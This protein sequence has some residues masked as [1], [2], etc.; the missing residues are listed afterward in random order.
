M[1]CCVVE[2]CFLKDIEINVYVVK[3][4]NILWIKI[5]FDKDFEVSL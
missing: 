3:C 1:I 5:F 4:F 2:Y